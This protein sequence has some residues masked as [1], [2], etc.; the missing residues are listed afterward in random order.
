MDAP[1]NYLAHKSS[2]VIQISKY[3][4]AKLTF[5]LRVTDTSVAVE[6]THVFR[7]DFIQNRQEK[8]ING[9]MYLMYM[10]NSHVQ[11]NNCA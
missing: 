10:Y 9:Y 1:W 4:S 11:G 6:C 2:Y 7:C 3:V 5:K 8:Q